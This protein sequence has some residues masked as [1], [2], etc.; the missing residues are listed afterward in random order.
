MVFLERLKSEYAYLTGAVRILRRV[1]PIANNRTRTFPDLLDDLVASHGDRVALL[2]QT[3]EL[4]Y[5]QLWERANRYSRWG[6]SQGIRRGDTVAL[7]M[8]NR[9]EYLAV[10]IGLI[11]IGGVVALINTNLSGRA[12]KHCLDIVDTRQIIAAPELAPEIDEAY[13]G[14]APPLWVSGGRTDK[15]D[16]LDDALEKESGTPLAPLDRVELTTDQPALYIYTS[17]TMGLPKAA[18]INHYRVQAAMAA[19]AALTRARKSDR[20][21]NTLPM[22]HTTGGVIAPGIALMSGG[23]CFIRDRFSASRFWDD[24][25]QYDCTMFQYIGE[26][27]RYL[28]NAPPH[29]GEKQHRIR[30]CNGNG[31]RPDIWEAFKTRFDIPEIIEWYAATEGNVLLFNMDGKPGAIGRVPK[32]LERKFQTKVIRFDIDTETPVRGPDGRCIECSPGEVGEAV[33]RITV[34]PSAPGQRFDGYADREETERKILRDAFAPG[35]AWFRTGDLMKRDELGY[36]YFVDRIG[37]TFRWKGEN[38]STSEV[39]EII[40]TFGGVREVTVYGVPVPNH[41]GNAGMAALVVED[42]LDLEA[43]RKHMEAELPGYA[44]PLFLRLRAEIEVTGTFKQRK[45]HLRQEGFDPDH[46]ADD[47]YF[48]DREGGGFRKLDTALRSRIV[49]G[50]IRL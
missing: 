31:L 16:S 21:Y 46:I 1:T 18:V 35:D 17:G 36:F 6:L 33:G 4:T 29:S 34:D 45:L 19:Y 44:V 49:S 15:H 9:P 8:P 43:L 41:D 37:D 27:C 24:V 11:R 32:W 30:V 47:L 14:A 48:N 10:W 28:L 5:R 25:V 39:A 26:L 23:S 50:E 7:M 13:A 12:L 20:I 40:A 3:E 42:S 22:Y 38:V 2:S